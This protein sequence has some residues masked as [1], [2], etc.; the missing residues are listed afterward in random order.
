MGNV[1]TSFARFVCEPMSRFT[2]KTSGE[3]STLVISRLNDVR[4]IIAIFT[5]YPL[6][7][8]KYLNF[9]AFSSEAPFFL[10]LRTKKNVKLSIYI[11]QGLSALVRLL[12]K[13]LT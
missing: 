1:F 12:K 11:Q 7:S 10:V 8:T 2:H 4:E 9:L 13:S 6:N 5:K 3:T